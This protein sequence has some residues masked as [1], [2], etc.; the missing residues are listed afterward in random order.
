MQKYL[1][2]PIAFQIRLKAH[3]YIL[4]V[5]SDHAQTYQI[6]SHLNCCM[7]Y[8][9]I[10]KSQILKLVFAKNA[11]VFFLLAKSLIGF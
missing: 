5:A 8:K 11:L 6:F 4:I 10:L 3:F 1:A 7:V 9:A 2:G